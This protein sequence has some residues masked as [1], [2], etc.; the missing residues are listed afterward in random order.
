MRVPATV[1]A[2][3]ALAGGVLVVP[4][5]TAQD[6]PPTDPGDLRVEA[7]VAPGAGVPDPR[8]GEA[9]A[10]PKVAEL[11][12]TATQVQRELGDLA[13]RIAQARS[14][15][16]EASAALER[17][18]AERAAAERAVAA[19]Q[20]EVDQFAKS[21]FTAMG[22]ADELRLVLTAAS[23]EDLLAG[24]SMVGHLRAD[25]DS[26]LADASQRHRR[27][28]AAELTALGIEGTAAE[29]KANLERRNGDATNRADAVSS[30]LRGPIDEANAAVVA[31]QEAQRERNAKTAANWNAYVD[32][33]KD[34]GITPPRAGSLRDPARLPGDLRPL[35]GEDG[36]PE[37]GVAQASADGERLLVLPKETIAAVSA[38]VDALGKPYVPRDH[39]E[40]PAS[41]SCD[42]LVRSVFADAG[43]KVPARIAEQ[44]AVGKRVP[45]ADA[46]PGDLVFIGPAKYGVQHV[47]IVLDERTMLAADGR[48]SGVVVTD[49]P[50]GDSILGVARPALGTGDERKVP[51]RAEGE[52]TWRCGGVEL[53]K[54]TFTSN[55]QAAGAWGGYPNGLIPTSALCAIGIGSHALRCDA[56]Q[57]FVLMTRAFAAE[58]GQGLCVTDSYRTFNAQV[59]L[60]R[61]KPALAAVPGTSNHGWG[62]ALDMCGGVQSFGTPQYA[63][64]GANGQA[65]GWV[66]PGWARQGGGREEPWHWEFVGRA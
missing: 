15:L 33:L 42:G 17:A 41:Y 19:Q 14:E 3:L 16:N 26:R 48:L 24:T 65:F 62:L 51:K 59:D 5:A 45:H 50:T 29:R 39:G 27:A 1:L 30:E 36:K 34:A 21:V 22:R 23:P 61:R 32:T 28:V 10:D 31:A 57:A 6:Q 46:Q 20:A 38:A 37:A 11:Q 55:G 47:G 35:K 56:A 43:L 8:P 25:Q 58:F 40:G 13:G 49:L 4:H 7:G 44:Y 52:L 12:R 2:A 63:W 66:N 64:L 18:R 54:S 60:Y 53:P 9:F